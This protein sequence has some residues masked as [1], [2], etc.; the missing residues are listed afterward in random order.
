MGAELKRSC[1]FSSQLCRGLDD[2]SGL[3]DHDVEQMRESKESQ[4]ILYSNPFRVS[5]CS[6]NLYRMKGQIN[7]GC[8][9][10]D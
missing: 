1:I 10:S 9:S 4:K 3:K 6:A 8:V 7:L 2:M 5:D